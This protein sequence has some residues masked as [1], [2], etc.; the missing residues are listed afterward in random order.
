MKLTEAVG[1]R[2]ARTDQASPA[3]AG[4]LAH[5]ARVAFQELAHAVA[6][7]CRSTRPSAR[8]PGRS[9]PGTAR[10]HPRLRRS[11]CTWP[12]SGSNARVSSSGGLASGAPH[13]IAPQDGG[14][15]EAEAVDVIFR[16]PS[17]AGNPAP[18]SRT[19]GLLQFSV[20]P[21]PAEVVVI[22]F[23][24]QH[25]I[26]LVIDAPEGDVRP[27]LVALGGVVEDHIQA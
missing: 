13:G 17:S 8:R 16:Q 22:A 10:R 21:R 20:L 26:G 9:R 25:I 2:A 4:P 11:A 3:G 19:I 27:V 24:G 12:G 18:C 6:D 23:R 15:V 5:H 7:I 1:P 14:Q